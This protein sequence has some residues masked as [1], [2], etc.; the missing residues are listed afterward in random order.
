MADGPP[1]IFAQKLQIRIQISARI[2]GFRIA[3]DSNPGESDG[4]QFD[5]FGRFRKRL[6]NRIRRIQ[7]RIGNRLRGRRRFNDWIAEAGEPKGLELI[8]FGRSCLE[9][10]DT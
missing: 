10:T 5:R 7:K 4:L 3:E 2:A 9:T 6:R 1:V 8:R